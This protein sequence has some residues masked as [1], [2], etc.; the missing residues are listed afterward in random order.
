MGKTITYLFLTV[1]FLASA[2]SNGGQ[3]ISVYPKIGIGEMIYLN[4]V[5]IDG[6]YKKK[7][8]LAGF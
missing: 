4:T 2:C 5:T 7:K 3:K 6:E 1:Y 8:I